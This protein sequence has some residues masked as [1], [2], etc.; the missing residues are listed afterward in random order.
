MLQLAQAMKRETAVSGSKPALRRV[1][2]MGSE[3]L[4]GS[5]IC[6]LRMFTARERS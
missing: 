2:K 3:T 4:V 6:S 1:W 5:A